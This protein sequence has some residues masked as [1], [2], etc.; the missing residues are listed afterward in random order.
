MQLGPDVIVAPANA[1]PAAA[2][3]ATATIP[4]VAPSFSEAVAPQLVGDFAHPIANVTGI[5]TVA[6]VTVAKLFELVHQTIPA[7]KRI[8]WVYWLLQ[9]TDRAMIVR[10]VDEAGAA[11]GLDLVRADISTREDLPGA[12]AALATA[13][14]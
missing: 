10:T 13:R 6:G 5:M 2:K 7:A 11:L 8:G 1:A 12:F 9:P 3:A 4:I 14:V